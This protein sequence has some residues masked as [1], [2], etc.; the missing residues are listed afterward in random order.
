MHLCSSRRRR[1][2]GAT[3]TLAAERVTAVAE[4][5]T[6]TPTEDLIGM[7][8]GIVVE[9]IGEIAVATADVIGVLIDTMEE[10]AAAVDARKI[11]SEL[12]I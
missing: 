1:R 3:E 10:E 9:V 12:A 5:E 8:P 6:G 7:T 2:T 11:L 4:T